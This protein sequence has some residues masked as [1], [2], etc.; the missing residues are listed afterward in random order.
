MF[1]GPT[2]I[3][4]GVVMPPNSPLIEKDEVEHFAC[5]ECGGSEFRFY[6]TT[7]LRWFLSVGDDGT[8]SYDRDYDCPDDDGLINEIMCENPGCGIS[9][10]H[11]D[12]VRFC[13]R[14]PE[15]SPAYTDWIGGIDPALRPEKEP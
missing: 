14:Y 3:H 2:H 6:A 7:S 12:V 11:E 1:P 8:I 10:S 9:L 13:T 4:K 15:F 5:P